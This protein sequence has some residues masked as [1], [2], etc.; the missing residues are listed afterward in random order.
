MKKSQNRVRANHRPSAKRNQ[1]RASAEPSAG[2]QEKP[3]GKT[4][5]ANGTN[6]KCWICMKAEG[7]KR[8]GRFNLCDECWRRTQDNLQQGTERRLGRWVGEEQWNEFKATAATY[9]V[10]LG[11][12]LAIAMQAAVI[13]D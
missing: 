3:E 10:T 1:S 8:D 5:L 7:T 11:E 4:S 6:K 2:T 9:D 13:D 12:F